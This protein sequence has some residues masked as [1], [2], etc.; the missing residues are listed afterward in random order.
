MKTNEQKKPTGAKENSAAGSEIVNAPQ[1]GSDKSLEGGAP[2]G[3]EVPDPGGGNDSDSLETQELKT[4]PFFAISEEVVIVVLGT[5]ESL[6]LLD[7]VW[8]RQAAPAAIM[9]MNVDGM[10]FREII[11]HVIADDGLPDTFI[12]VPASCFPTHRV[13][14]ADLISYKVRVMPTGERIHTTGLPAMIETSIATLVLEKL[15]TKGDFSEEE[16]M[17]A[18]NAM[19]HGDEIPVEI[20]NRIAGSVRYASSSDPCKA[21]ILEALTQ[22]KFLNVAANSFEPIKQ[23][24]TKFY[25]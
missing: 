10:S 25:G 15:D 22:R 9:S 14:L 24:L 7:K 1:G 6:P 2:S 23:M 17:E 12:L 18:Y 3:D 11:E 16:F 8:E 21:T 19:A 20:G 13:S 5:S 4:V